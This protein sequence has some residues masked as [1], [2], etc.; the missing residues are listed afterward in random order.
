MMMVNMTALSSYLHRYINRTDH[1]VTLTSPQQHLQTQHPGPRQ[2]DGELCQGQHQYWS[3]PRRCCDTLPH[4]PHPPPS[5]SL[6]VNW[7]Q[8]TFSN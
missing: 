8:Q 3:L 6:E 5:Q 1:Q 2:R 4:S 7:K